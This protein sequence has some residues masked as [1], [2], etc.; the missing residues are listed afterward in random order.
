MKFNKKIKIENIEISD[1]S[2]A[3][4]IAEAGVNHGGNI[5][6][7]KRLIDVACDA[8]A[9]A[10]KFQTFKVK[11]LILKNVSKAPYQHKTTD[12]SESQFEMLRKLEVT[13]EQNIQ[14][15]EYCEKKEIIFLTTPFDEGSLEELNELDLSAY[16]IASTDLTNLP[17]LEKVAKKKKPIIL[18]TGMSYLTEIDLALKII[19]QFNK[20]VILLQCTANYPVKDEEV[21]L[22]I[23]KTFM[24][25]YSMLVGY[26]D[27]SVGIGAAPY[28]IPIGAKVIE[29]HFTL[30]KSLEGPDHRASL[31]V[32]E[33]KDF[34][35]EIRKVEKYM[36]VSDKMPTISEMKTKLSLQKC[37]VAACDIKKGEVFTNKN[38]I[39]K[40]TGGI[41]ISP[42]YYN[43]LI[44]QVA[45]K[46]FEKDEII[47][48]ID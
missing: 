32:E 21:N 35:K 34:I 7:A 38:I 43:N 33:L 26:S 39:A 3:F 47:E 19:H 41:G 48:V 1:Q 36:G 42:I 18:S 11:N 4:I 17:F 2:K 6:F 24:N 10:V 31:G 8:R 22:S 27:H 44:G 5:E 20:N 23:I 46:E 29:K 37:F 13:K 28:A 40:R 16:K 15:K 12:S 45:C 25:K 9:D 30:D 14:L